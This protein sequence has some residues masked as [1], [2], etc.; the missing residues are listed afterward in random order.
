M[1]SSPVIPIATLPDEKAHE[2]STHRKRLIRTTEQ[3]TG[4]I[5]T[6]N[7]AWLD[8]KGTLPAHTHDDGE[9]YYFFLE[10]SGRILVGQTWHTVTKHDFVTIAKKT[11]HSVANTG[12]TPLVFV[13]IRTVL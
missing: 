13:T 7:Y 4:S 10:G 5:A 3:K 9:E 1:T 2:G 8:P 11:I 12:T 6:V